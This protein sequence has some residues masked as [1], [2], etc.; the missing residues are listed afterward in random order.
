MFNKWKPFPKC[1][2]KKEGM[3]LCTIKYGDEEHQ[4]YV[5]DLWWDPL[6]KIWKDKRRLVIFSEYDVFDYAGK[7]LHYDSL[8]ERDNVI[9]FMNLPKVYKKLD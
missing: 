8:C 2:P 1:T 6:L 7:L 9:A 3:Y 5:I 4:T